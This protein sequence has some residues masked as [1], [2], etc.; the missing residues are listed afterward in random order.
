MNTRRCSRSSK[1]ISVLPHLSKELYLYLVV[2]PLS[3]DFVLVGGRLSLE[4]GLL[5]Q[6][7]TTKC[8][9]QVYLARKKLIFTL[10]TLA[11]KFSPYFQ[12][13]IMVVLTDQPLKMALHRL[14]MAGRVA[15]WALEITKFDLVF[16]PRSSVKA[17]VLAD[18]VTECTIIRIARG[19]QPGR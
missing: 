2:L 19:R 15:K 8:R 5:H 10:I 1:T 11:R 16:R 17:Q 14:D 13:H 3:I 7:S 18:F 6:Q 9:N 4:T 12:A